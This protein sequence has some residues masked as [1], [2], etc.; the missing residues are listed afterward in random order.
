[1]IY[2]KKNNKYIFEKDEFKSV[3][4]PLKRNKNIIHIGVMNIFLSMPEVL[5]EIIFRHKNINLRYIFKIINTCQSEMNEN[6]FSISKLKWEEIIAEPFYKNNNLISCEEVVKFRIVHEK[7]DNKS[8]FYKMLSDKSERE[9]DEEFLR[10][11]NNS[12]H[13]YIEMLI[14]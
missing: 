7:W 12:E 9:L 11:H 1:M 2:S 6:G 13:K 3:I 10:K 5:F 8:N 14:Q 4:Y